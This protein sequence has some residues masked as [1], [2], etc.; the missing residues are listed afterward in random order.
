MANEV[1][2]RFS[3]QASDAIRQGARVLVLYLAPNI[4]EPLPFCAVRERVR[5]RLAPQRREPLCRPL[6]SEALLVLQ[7]ELDHCDRP[8]LCRPSRK[9]S[10]SAGS[11][12]G[13]AS[14]IRDTEKS[15]FRAR[16]CSASQV[17]SS[18]RPA[19]A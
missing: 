5:E 3:V 12:K 14:L 17:A 16:T 19:C 11:L 18:I 9:C 1:I 4:D 13:K 15:G 7:S 10:R 2:S 6:A 8:A